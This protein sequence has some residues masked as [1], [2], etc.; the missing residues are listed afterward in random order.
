M[1]TI[2]AT[3]ISPLFIIQI[4]FSQGFV[5]L[6]FESSDVS[7]YSSGTFNSIPM[8]QAFPDWN[9][10][11][12]SSSSTNAASMASYNVLPLSTAAIS[13]GDTNLMPYFGPLQGSYSAFLFGAN[14]YA[15]KISQ[16]GLVPLGTQSFLLD[17]ADITGI[18]G[19]SF[20]VLIGDQA[21]N[22]TALQVFPSYTLYSGDVSSFSG[23]TVNLSI[24]VPPMV[25]PNDPNGW[26]F[27]SIRF[28]TN[29]TPEPSAL[30]LSA[31]GGLLLAWR[32][33]KNLPM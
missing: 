24:V 30:A 12:I 5:N 9:G 13:I 3:F 29:P 14:G 16:T 20:T 7:G 11:Y 28:S 15:S 10:Y 26:E 2:I 1:K 27:D 6:N 31:L 21:I 18:F 25:N 23:Q 8:N 33:R 19:G 17:V 22:M 4:G 32:W